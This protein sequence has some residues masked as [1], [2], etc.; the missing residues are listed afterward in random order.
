MWRAG[1]R[2]AAADVARGRAQRQGAG[3]AAAAGGAGR[4]GQHACRARACAAGALCR[5]A[6]AC[7]E[8]SLA[9]AAGRGRECVCL[10]GRRLICAPRVCAS[11]AIAVLGL[12]LNTLPGVCCGGNP[13]QILQGVPRTLPGR[14][15]RLV[16]GT[17]LWAESLW[18]SVKWQAGAMLWKVLAMK[19]AIFVLLWFMGLALLGLRVVL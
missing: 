3:R 5:A 12:R 16:G 8:P 15:S 4:H 18:L 2:A 6:R 11:L 13:G 10:R 9:C 19:A 14:S 7:H 1:G 17:Q